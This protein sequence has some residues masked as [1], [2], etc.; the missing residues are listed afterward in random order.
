MA[1]VIGKAQH[2]MHNERKETRIEPG[3][4]TTGSRSMGKC[5][6]FYLCVQNGTK[7]VGGYG[8]PPNAKPFHKFMATTQ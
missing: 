2:H 1:T 5:Q 6:R 8:M 3:T 7:A 4:T